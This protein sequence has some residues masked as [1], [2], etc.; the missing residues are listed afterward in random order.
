[1]FPELHRESRRR[2][3]FGP[4]KGGRV[5]P[6]SAFQQQN[7]FLFIVVQSDQVRLV[8]DVVDLVDSEADETEIDEM[9]SG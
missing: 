4:L 9:I 8:V 7:C 3:V 1:M 6:I 2:N 5:D